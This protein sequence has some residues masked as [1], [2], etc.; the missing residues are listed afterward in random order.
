MS[1]QWEIKLDKAAFGSRVF[2]SQQMKDAVQAMNMEVN[3]PMG[4]RTWKGN[5]WVALPVDYH[6]PGY[7]PKPGKSDYETARSIM[8]NPKS[9]KQKAY[10]RYL[11]A[12]AGGGGRNG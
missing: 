10:A 6:A 1:K 8:R 2:R 4:T 5:R 12:K 7:V 3:G 9:D 11:F